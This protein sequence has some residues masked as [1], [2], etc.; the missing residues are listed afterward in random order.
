M[1]VRIFP[2]LESL[3]LAAANLFVEKAKSSIESTGQFA[4]ALAGGN[5]PKELYRLLASS[6]YRGQVDW[7][8]VQFFFGDERWVPRSDPASNEGM[9]REN[10]L[11]LIPA[12]PENIHPMYTGGSVEDACASYEAKLKQI[13]PSGLDFTML[14]MG[15]DGHTASLFPGISELQEEQLWVVPTQSPKGVPQRISL[16]FPALEKS[17][18]IL[19]LVAGADK[20]ANLELALSRQP[21][22]WP[23]SGVLAHRA[24]N[25]HWFLD[26]LAAGS[27][28]APSS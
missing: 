5:T 14:G 13:A 2:D 8:R 10:L 18:L 25:V 27:T 23:P 26:P 11:N 24:K 28:I 7:A 4:V 12:K 19:F 16:T 3:S 1:K 22:S 20:H 15:D 9:A 6:P 21:Q 17:Q